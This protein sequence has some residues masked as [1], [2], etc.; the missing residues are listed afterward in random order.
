MN[1]PRWQAVCKV[2]GRTFP[3]S[4][5]Q[6]AELLKLGWPVCCDGDMSILYHPNGV[7]PGDQPAEPE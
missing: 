5:A 2:C 3:V 4:E 6:T 1:P 7:P